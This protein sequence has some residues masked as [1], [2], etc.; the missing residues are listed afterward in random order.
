M[1]S[2]RVT[3]KRIGRN[4]AVPDLVTKAADADDLAV[5]VHK[6]ARKHL[7]SRNYNVA[8]D[9][10]EGTGFIACGMHNGGEFTIRAEGT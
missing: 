6:Y 2:Y 5:A 7:A 8:V 3:F 10:G 9:L 4:H 1:T